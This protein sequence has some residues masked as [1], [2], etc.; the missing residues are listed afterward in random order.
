MTI[1]EFHKKHGI[2]M[3]ERKQMQREHDEIMEQMALQA[4]TELPSMGSDRVTGTRLDSEHPAN[5]LARAY[6]EAMPEEWRAKNSH[7]QVF[8]SVDEEAK[9]RVERPRP[10]VDHSV[11]ALEREFGSLHEP[12]RGS[13]YDSK[14][15][16]PMSLTY[17]KM[18]VGAGGRARPYPS[19]G[20]GLRGTAAAMAGLQQ[21]L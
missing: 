3:E 8:A 11:E 7:D 21:Q 16:F 17:G 1:D 14:V 4:A 13:A 18:Q 6:P 9:A 19:R 12:E 20:R 10:E 5:I 2:T 15:E